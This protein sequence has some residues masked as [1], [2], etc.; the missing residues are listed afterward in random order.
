M[1]VNKQAQPVKLSAEY[2]TA[3]PLW[4]RAPTRTDSG[5]LAADFMMLVRN[6]NKL[7]SQQQQTVLNK[8]HT[9]LDLYN[10]QVLLADLNLKINLLWVSHVPR[11]GLGFEI[12][13]QLHYAVPEAKLIS[14]QYI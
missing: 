6:L 14:Q 13:A 10:K 7:A 2:Q 3:E 11:P 8:L 5:E 4:L 9:V 12:A 1:L